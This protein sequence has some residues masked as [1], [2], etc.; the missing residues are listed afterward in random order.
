MVN[1]VKSRNTTD[2]E[3]PPF[4]HF[5]KTGHGIVLPIFHNLDPAQ[6]FRN[7]IEN[8]GLTSATGIAD[9]TGMSKGQISKSGDNHKFSG[10]KRVGR[11]RRWTGGGGVKVSRF[12][13]HHFS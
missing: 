12:S 11:W 5:Q 2:E 4:L 10:G 7:C 13:F 1:S 9:E 8:L 6:A 3:V